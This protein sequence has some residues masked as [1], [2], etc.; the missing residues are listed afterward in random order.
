MKCRSVTGSVGIAAK[1]M[2]HHRA[3]FPVK[4]G[5]AL[6]KLT[7]RAVAALL[8]NS[9]MPEPR[10][11]YSAFDTH[12]VHAKRAVNSSGDR[13]GSVTELLVHAHSAVVKPRRSK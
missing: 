12:T 1:V 10:K 7:A 11:L 4:S 5:E 2:P 9:D 13:R 8:S 6:A 3:R